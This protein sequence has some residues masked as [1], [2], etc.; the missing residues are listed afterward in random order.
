MRGNKKISNFKTSKKPNYAQST[1]GQRI[2]RAKQ[3]ATVLQTSRPSE[4]RKRGWEWRWAEGTKE[5]GKNIRAMSK[6]KTK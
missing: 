3:A 6:K 4:H 5:R 1:S 2:K